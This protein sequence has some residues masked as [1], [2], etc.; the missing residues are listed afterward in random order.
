MQSV[1]SPVPAACPAPAAPTDVSASRKRQQVLQ[2]AAELFITQGYGAVSMDAVARAAGVSKATLYAHFASKDALFATIVGDACRRS[3]VDEA[4][5]PEHPQDVEAALRSLGRRL[6][7]FL[8]E[9]RTLAIARVAIAESARFPELGVAFLAN[10]PIAFQT[11]IAAWLGVL[12]AQGALHAPD[13]GVAAQ[14]LGA[15]LR[16]SLHLEA[17]LRPDFHPDEVQIDA[18]VDAAVA[19]FLRAYAPQPAAA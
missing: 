4:N 3:P 2:A 14:H 18:A 1:V 19:A 10:G 6:L 16:G 5:F 8:L 15:L 11:R 13:A 7:R 17:I 9:P 12:H